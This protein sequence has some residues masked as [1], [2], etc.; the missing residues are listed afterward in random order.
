MEQTKL[1][2]IVKL[3]TACA[4]LFVVI[5]VSVIIGQ[6]VKLHKLNKELS[7]L[8]A[9]ITAQTQKRY[10][11]SN[12][13]ENRSTSIYLEEYVRDELGMIDEDETYFNI[14]K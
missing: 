12:S 13:I 2:N 14:E 3:I 10:D 7:Q 8:Q 11:L 5:L 1:N 6:Y 9:D 4:T